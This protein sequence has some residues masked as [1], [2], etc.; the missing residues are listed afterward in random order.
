LQ[1]VLCKSSENQLAEKILQTMEFQI[2]GLH[3]Q[4]Q[5]ELSDSQFTSSS[6]ALFSFYAGQNVTYAEMLKSFIHF[7]IR[8]AVS[9][10]KNFKFTYNECQSHS[11]G[12]KQ[13][14]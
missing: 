14:N 6:L 7:L 5:V 11:S 10:R 1:L 3:V 13:M 12:M 4:L 9:R 2:A 8:M